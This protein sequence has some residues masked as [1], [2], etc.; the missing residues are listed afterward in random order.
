MRCVNIDWLECYCHEDAIGYP[1]DAA[2]F[3]RL[4]YQ[5]HERDFGTP[6]YHEMFTILDRDG[7]P[8][9]EVRRKPK[10]DTTMRNGVLNPYSC[11]VRLANRAC[12]FSTAVANFVLFLQTAGMKFQRIF[13]L[14]I[15]YDFTTFDFGDEPHKFMQRYMSGKYSKI[16]Q[17]NISAHGVDQWDGRIWNSVSWGS[18]KSMV[19]TKFYCKTLEL[20]QAK[21]K[22]YI[23]QAWQLAGLVDD[24]WSLEKRLPDGTVKKPEI[25]RV[26]FSLKSSVKRWF[27]IEDNSARKK[28][29]RSVKHDLTMYATT[30]KLWDVF[31]SL[32][33]HYFHF[34]HFEPDKRKDRCKDKELF[35]LHDVETF[36][37]LDKVA[38]DEPRN[39]AVDSL[40]KRLVLFRDSSSRPEVYRAC[41]VILEQLER[42]GRLRDIVGEITADEAKVLQ[43]LVAKR[44]QDKTN[45]LSQDI[46]NCINAV[47]VEKSLWD[48]STDF[49]DK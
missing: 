22:P 4:G 27:V 44:L 7:L 21:D 11:H 37:H 1:H 8:F 36:Y 25:W 13:R 43:M 18:P 32:A 46:V 14:D 40:Y 49:C 15:C 5:V 47:A 19:S 45:P 29:L 31:A 38:S 48:M 9:V 34:K 23:R 33:E 26:E 12:Y 41:N 30:A 28:K 35:D 10:S 2:F 42:D 3:Q 24:S 17:A 39:N 16:N 20:R 6:V